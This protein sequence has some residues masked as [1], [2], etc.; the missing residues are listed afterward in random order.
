SSRAEVRAEEQQPAGF[1][2][3][4]VRALTNLYHAIETD[5]KVSAFVPATAQS[6]MLPLGSLRKMLQAFFEQ[7]DPKKTNRK[8]LEAFMNQ[9]EKVKTAVPMGLA[10]EKKEPLIEIFN[11]VLEVLKPHRQIARPQAETQKDVRATSTSQMARESL[12]AL[13]AAAKPQIV[14]A[15]SEVEPPTKTTVNL[16]LVD[17]TQGRRSVIGKEDLLWLT[18]FLLSHVEKNLPIA[19]FSHFRKEIEEPLSALRVIYDHLKTGS[20]ENFAAIPGS[21]HRSVVLIE[22]VAR[23]QLVADH[24]AIIEDTFPLVQQMIYATSEKSIQDYKRRLEEALKGRTSADHS[25]APPSLSEPP[26]SDVGVS[27]VEDAILEAARA[28]L[29]SE[30]LSDA[31]RIKLQQQTAEALQ[32]RKQKQA[33]RKDSGPAFVGINLQDEWVKKL[34]TSGLLV[35]VDQKSPLDLEHAITALADGWKQ[36]SRKAPLFVA[37]HLPERPAGDDA[38]ALLR[39]LRE[40][41]DPI[42]N[43]LADLRLK[44]SSDEVIFG[45]IAS[46]S[47][48]L[49]KYLFDE[50]RWRKTDVQASPDHPL[51]LTF[52]F[53]LT[54][55]PENEEEAED[56]MDA[57]SSH[58]FTVISTLDSKKPLEQQIK[59]ARFYG[60]SALV[61]NAKELTGPQTNEETLKIL[62]EA[63][64]P[65]LPIS[66]IAIEQVPSFLKLPNVIGVVLGKAILRHGDGSATP[67]MISERV[68]H[69]AGLISSSRAA[70]SKA[71]EPASPEGRA[72]VR[73]LNVEPWHKIVVAAEKNIGITMEQRWQWAFRNENPELEKIL[74]QTYG[75]ADKAKLLTFW[76][77]Q[78]E[79][80]KHAKTKDEVLQFVE[81][82]NRLYAYEPSE[83]LRHI[84]AKINNT[85]ELPK[86]DRVFYFRKPADRKP[87]EDIHTLPVL[88]QAYGLDP[89]YSALGLDYTPYGL[90]QQIE[91]ADGE[92]LT[93]IHLWLREDF[94]ALDVAT[95]YAHEHYHIN[96]AKGFLNGLSYIVQPGL[97]WILREGT[98]EY[99]ARNFI[100]RHFGV[101]LPQRRG[102]LFITEFFRKIAEQ[103]DPKLLYE[104]HTT[105]SFEALRKSGFD[106]DRLRMLQDYMGKE[107]GLGAMRRTFMPHMN[108]VHD[109][110][111]MSSDANNA[112]K[113][114]ADV[115]RTSR[116]AEVR[117]LK[118]GQEI[119]GKGQE[120]LEQKTLEQQK[121]ARLIVEPSGLDPY[122]ARFT[123]D[124]KVNVT[125][126]PSFGNKDDRRSSAANLRF[127][128]ALSGFERES[129]PSRVGDS[130]QYENDEKSKKFEAALH[131]KYEP[132]L[133]VAIDVTQGVVDLVVLASP[134][135]VMILGVIKDKLSK[136]EAAIEPIILGP[137]WK[138]AFEEFGERILAASS[139]EFRKSLAVVVD[140]K[141]PILSQL[142]NEGILREL[143]GA[144]IKVRV[145]SADR[146]VRSLLERVYKKMT[147]EEKG[148]LS[149]ILKLSPKSLKRY[150]SEEA[151]NGAGTLIE[152]PTRLSELDRNIPITILDSQ[153]LTQ[154]NRVELILPALVIAAIVGSLKESAA[155]ALR[156]QLADFGVI[157]SVRNGQMVG[158]ISLV[159]LS[160]WFNAQMS[161]ELTAKAA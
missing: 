95:N 124:D 5:A 160:V 94:E 98:V 3:E 104:F 96:Q 18:E 38:D 1:S 55:L 47:V 53:I 34:Q 64:I 43:T 112:L 89:I 36:G 137:R 144:G 129:S 77:K 2:D 29:R 103:V 134:L 7:D 93:L 42:L 26:V 63:K 46:A 41:I 31:D 22:N 48:S 143:L 75:T 119:R 120:V 61:V 109:F 78:L 121:T 118:Q 138:P 10:K 130:I 68:Q 97:L 71:G 140:S 35:H 145:S 33:G 72:E 146:E 82:T 44:Y 125:Q 40:G 79:K 136:E 157:V 158:T 23:V 152:S 90:V 54:K 45:V 20:T 131:R 50:G 155:A 148:K 141:N 37:V 91:L 70:A 102:H 113:K 57:A 24:R 19:Q 52:E 32:L 122:S 85:G 8:R 25:I 9:I 153:T 123:R 161:K 21:V 107:I 80:M 28:L 88:E 62:T 151:K 127:E 15:K 76:Q 154:R 87:E 110:L 6:F 116:R 150:A 81:E 69:L 139:R 39:W 66:G 128:T 13:K 14:P 12:Q 59:N 74:L 101:H 11:D 105:G 58:G 149:Q 86:P 17:Q 156:K 92:M 30:D 106:P 108:L 142:F 83:E 16:G 51:D 60:V 117:E 147:A 56:F 27:S 132:F 73:Q 67:K 115:I 133:H 114:I 135:G 4:E 111:D 159:K 84:I 126:K 100:H 65:L 49:L 99:L